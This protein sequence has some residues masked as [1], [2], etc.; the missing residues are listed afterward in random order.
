MTSNWSW[1]ARSA[2][3]SAG[4]WGA[5]RRPVSRLRQRRHRLAAQ[6]LGRQARGLHVDFG[7]CDMV[8]LRL[9]QHFAPQPELAFEALLVLVE[10]RRAGLAQRLANR[11]PG[12]HQCGERMQP[13]Q[14]AQ[15]RADHRYRRFPFL[16]YPAQDAFEPRHIAFARG[17]DRVVELERGAVADRKERVLEFDPTALA[18]IER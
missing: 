15:Q 8:E 9:Q 3:G 12:G 13:L 11:R 6:G 7:L 18:D 10:D 1:A 16:E 4:N 2:I 17:H 5:E 14:M